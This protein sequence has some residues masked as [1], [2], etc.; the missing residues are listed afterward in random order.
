MKYR[1][2]F[3]LLGAAIVAAAIVVLAVGGWGAYTWL[4][5][6]VVV[7]EAQMGPVV[8]AFYATGTVQPR[9]EYAVNTSI[10]GI[11]TQVNVDKGDRVTKGQILAI[12]SDP[13]LDYAVHKA[14]A[15]LDEKIALANPKTSP[16][17]AELDARI[18]AQK[19]LM[20]IAQR[21][22]DRQQELI[23][24]NA[25]SQTDLDR[26][27]ERYRQAR[28][29]LEALE[30]Q[31][32]MKA[33]ALQRELDVAK[34]AL[35]TAQWSQ[36]LQTVKS[37]IDGVVLDRPVSRGTRVAANDHLM[38]TAD[39]SPSNLVM[40]AAVD[41]EDHDQLRDDQLVQMVL[42]SFAGETFEGRVDKI[43]D[44]ADPD[45]RTFE[46]D[47]R[48]TPLRDRLAPGMTG[49]LAF[50]TQSKQDALTVPAEALQDGRIWTVSNGRAHALE[51]KTGV[52][53]VQRVE[54]TEGLQRGEIVILSAT[55]DLSDGQRVRTSYQDARQIAAANAPKAAEAFKGFNP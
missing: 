13:V 15:E 18:D 51:I 43:Y 39:L 45:R 32:R 55:D 4:R 7:T 34:A 5:P 2:G 19:V 22:R 25:A 54:V 17:L 38:Q 33:L 8:S 3:T 16:A 29:D 44:Q 52:K 1:Q 35:K 37:P 6:K 20:D 27:L 47:I 24:Q 21:E 36:D 14:Q 12:V 11:V 9:H 46:V 10:A 26:S 53:N 49:E 42:Y 50:I 28:G 41:E 23:K 48:F 30:A 31:R 40:R